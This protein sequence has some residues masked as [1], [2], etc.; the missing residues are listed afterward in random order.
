MGDAAT[1]VCTHSCVYTH[2]H[3]RTGVYTAIVAGFT[4]YYCRVDCNKTWVVTSPI[5]RPLG[6]RHDIKLTYDEV[7]ILIFDDPA[8]L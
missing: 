2:V 7:R 3:A 1:R 8:E 5:A 4:V 6:L